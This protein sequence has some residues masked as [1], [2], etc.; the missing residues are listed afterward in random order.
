MPEHAADDTATAAPDSWFIYR[1]TG[2][3]HS[4]IDELLPPPPPWRVFSEAPADGAPE[5]RSATPEDHRART[6][7]PARSVV[8]LI[9]AAIYLRRPVLVTGKPGVGKSTLARSIAY[10]LDLG[11]LLHWPVNSR[12]TLS[13]GLY[14]YDAIGRLQEANLRD[15]P[16]PPH[17]DRTADI[18]RY[19][20]LGPLGTALLPRSRPRVLLVDELD[21]GDLDLPNDLLDVFEEGSYT[22]PELA[23]LPDEQ[24]EVEVFTDD[25]GPR[26]T[27]RR[28]RVVCHAFPIVVITNNGERRFPPAFLRRCVRVDIQP[29]DS[30]ALAQIVRAQLGEEAVA[31]AEPVIER[32]LAKRSR[33]DIATDQLLNAV[34]FAMSGVLGDPGG[35]EAAEGADAH[36]R[37]RLLEALLRG[38]NA[39]D[40]S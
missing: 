3:P 18:G 38:I 8:E 21:K 12:S 19:I 22:I 20:R 9:N 15:A 31:A 32:F 2:V 26:A 39:M 27:I 16:G 13:E 29:H 4:D 40:P 37:E 6:Y 10:E 33:D 11:P 5:D 28:G 34:Y 30:R 24:R 36:T 23:R 17:G 14:R 1:G 7:R 25:H 35:Q